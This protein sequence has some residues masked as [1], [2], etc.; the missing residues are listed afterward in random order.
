MQ[1]IRS[2]DGDG[3]FHWLSVW[4]DG[5]AIH[6]K[7][8]LGQHCPVAFSLGAHNGYGAS[9]LLSPRSAEGKESRAM[10]I[11]ALDVVNYLHSVGIDPPVPL[12]RMAAASFCY[13]KALREVLDYR[14]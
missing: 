9:F 5:T 12:L 4:R 13:R 10:A 11:I 3:L 1:T 8:M 14:W 2:A 7:G 6:V